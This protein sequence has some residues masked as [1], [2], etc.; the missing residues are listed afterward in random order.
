[1]LL[2]PNKQFWGKQEAAIKAIISRQ[3][4]VI[5]IIGTG[6]RKSVLFMLLAILAPSRVTIVV[7]LLVL[8]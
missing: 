1:M 8:L 2:G 4:P 3:S 6:C 7:T 5:A